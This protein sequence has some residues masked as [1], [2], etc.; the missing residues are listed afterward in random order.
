MSTS[1]PLLDSLLQR[2]EL[3]HALELARAQLAHHAEPD[4]LLLAFGLEVRVHEFDRAAATLARLI[5]LAPQAAAG[6]EAYGRYARAEKRRLER[7]TD[8][9][10]AGARSAMLPPPPHLLAYSAA[11]VAHARGD[12][13]AA[14][15]ALEEA[16]ATRPRMSGTLVRHSGATVRF[17]DLVDLDALTGAV[18]PCYGGDALL[19]VPYSQLRSL[20]FHRGQTALDALWLPTELLL[21]DG[22]AARVRVPSLYTG[23]GLSSIAGAR[24]GNTTMFFYETGYAV[25]TGQRDLE[26]HG[27]D[28]GRSMIGLTAI[29]ELQL[30]PA[31]ARSN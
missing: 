21:V 14:A 31:T 27:E 26:V 5:E 7:L 15:T 10:V 6:L 28:G 13:A 23:S 30:D 12:H 19:D 20:K 11:A 29:A 22:T 4:L 9:E 3:H 2:G 8:P 18:L 1:T 17:I 25:G 24:L 16:N